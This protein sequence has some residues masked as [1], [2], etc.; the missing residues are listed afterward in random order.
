MLGL[1]AVAAA[2]CAST[3]D[4]AKGF[5]EDRDRCVGRLF[6]DPDSWWCGWSDA[7]QKTTVGDSTDEYL[8]A[9]EDMG[10]CRWVYVVDRESRRVTDWRFAGGEEDCYNRIDWLGP[11]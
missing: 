7:I 5:R 3:E 10:R 6:M 1:I 11:W 4:L 2:G 8:I 9:R